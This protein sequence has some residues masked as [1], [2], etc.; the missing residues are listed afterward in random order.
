M[1]RIHVV[2]HRSLCNERRS[3]ISGSEQFCYDG[4]RCVV[5]MVDSLS[6]SGACFIE[7]CI[8]YRITA[9]LYILVRMFTGGLCYLKFKDY[10][11][12]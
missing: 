2:I 9:K 12:I 6:R 3:S 4:A 10:R 5:F 11:I 7:E 1:V 8:L